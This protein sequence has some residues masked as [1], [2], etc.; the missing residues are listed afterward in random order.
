MNWTITYNKD[1]SY[2]VEPSPFNPSNGDTITEIYP[3]IPGQTIRELTTVWNDKWDKI[4]TSRHP[5]DNFKLE[6]LDFS[7]PNQLPL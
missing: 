7:Q 5:L 3:E 4:T 1:R 6:I 2:T